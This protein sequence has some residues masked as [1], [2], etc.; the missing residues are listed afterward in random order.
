MSR[1]KLP[2]AITRS[3]GDLPEVGT[4]A[5]EHHETQ[6]PRRHEPKNSEKSSESHHPSALPPNSAKTAPAA[7]RGAPKTS[8]RGQHA[9]TESRPSHGRSAPAARRR[10]SKS[11]VHQERAAAPHPAS[12]PQTIKAE[13][14]ARS[15]GPETSAHDEVDAAQPASLPDSAKGESTPATASR[16][17][18]GEL[19]PS[20]VSSHPEEPPATPPSRRAVAEKVVDRYKLYAA[21]GGLSPIPIMT[22]AGVTIV[23]LQMVKTLSN[24]YEVPFERDLTKSII[25]GLMGGA[26]PTGLG[27]ATASALALAIPGVGFVGV[28]VS[29][30]TASALT[31]R[32]GLVFVERFESG[33]MPPRVSESNA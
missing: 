7:H 4:G 32:I 8:S 1:K 5:G 26:V 17:L 21:M 2:R 33:A 13:A 24:L 11:S 31:G 14:A 15:S 22:A 3:T 19:L 20:T 6:R 9:G 18:E 10:A 29:A 28:A 23:V 12:P 16:P 27:V 30:L 25:V